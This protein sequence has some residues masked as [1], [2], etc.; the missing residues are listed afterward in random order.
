MAHGARA[1]NL[2]GGRAVAGEAEGQGI[3]VLGGRVKVRGIGPGAKAGGRATTREAGGITR[4]PVYE[5]TPG[6]P[7]VSGGR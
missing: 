4:G 6:G 2:E 5:T 3:G 1:G 7:G